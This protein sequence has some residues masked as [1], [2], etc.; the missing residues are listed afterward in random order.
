MT[1]VLWNITE[2]IICIVPDDHF[3]AMDQRLLNVSIPSSFLNGSSVTIILS[4]SHIL[5]VWGRGDKELFFLV[6]GLHVERS[7]TPGSSFTCGPGTDDKILDFEPM[8]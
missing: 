5:G 1:V 2:A 8:I 7:C 6:I 3:T 4:L